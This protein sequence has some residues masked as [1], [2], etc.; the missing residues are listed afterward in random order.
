MPAQGFTYA[1]GFGDADTICDVFDGSKI[2][3]RV[4]PELNAE[5]VLDEDA[6]DVDGNNMLL[7]VLLLLGLN[8]ELEILW[9][10]RGT[11]DDASYR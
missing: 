10:M 2:E 11:V 8:K 3:D 7:D 6:I 1:V 9:T 5:D 4:A